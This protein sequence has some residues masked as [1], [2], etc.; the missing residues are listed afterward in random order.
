M[1]SFFRFLGLA[2]LFLGLIIFF[3]TSRESIARFLGALRVRTLAF[4][5]ENALSRTLLEL[6]AENERLVREIERAGIKTPASQGDRYHYKTARVFSRYPFNDEATVV[7][8]LGSEDGMKEHMPVF[9]S[10]G[11]LLGKIR[12]VSRTQSEV[13]TIRNA[14]WR[15]SVTIGSEGTKAVYSGGSSPFLDLI[16]KDVKLHEGDKIVSVSPE[17]P[18]GTVLGTVGKLSGATYD[19]WQQAKVV[20]AYEPEAFSTVFVLVDFP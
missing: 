9:V 10:R 3:F 8:D 1:K 15:T 19:V 4:G 14:S 18:L 20:P 5:S 6:S 2:A 16:P 13:E 17:F 11:V 7:I 12:S